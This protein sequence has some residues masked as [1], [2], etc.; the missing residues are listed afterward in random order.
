MSTKNARDRV[1]GELRQEI[2][3]EAERLI[4][5]EGFPGL[6]MRRLASRLGC[7]PMSLYSYFADKEAL[8]CALGRQ[9]FARVA[10]RLAAADRTGGP[11]GLRELLL[12][13]VRYAQDDPVHYRA[14]FLSAPRVE[15]PADPNPAFRLLSGRVAD[16]VRSGRLHGDPDEVSLVLWTAAHGAASTIVNFGHRPFG[17]WEQYAAAAVDAVLA[18]VTT[19][20]RDQERAGDGDPDGTADPA[21]NRAAPCDQDAGGRNHAPNAEVTR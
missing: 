16:C 4:R 20:A 15:Q 9:G 17:S 21:R 2:L 6:T 18:G 12:E 14:L 10:D 11:A 7:A 3:D 1:R 13:F 8:L 19:A 5:E